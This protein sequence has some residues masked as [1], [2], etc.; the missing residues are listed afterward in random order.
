MKKET[1]AKFY[2]NYRLYIF[3]IMVALSSLFL[4]V[5]AIYPQTAKLIGNQKAQGDLINKS[6]F[7]ETK[8]LA[9]ESYDQ[10]DLSRK[11]GFALSAYPTDKDFGN[12]VGLLQQLV[13]QSG[14]NITSLALGNVPSKADVSSSYEIKLQITGAKN[15]LAVLLSNLEN[16]ARLMRVNSIDVSSGPN[17]QI[18]DVSLGVAV[19]YSSA[20]QSFGSVDSPVTKL[21]QADE[22]LITRLAKVS[23]VSVSPQAP[24]P[25]LP[26][27]KANPFE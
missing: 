11:V 2:L 25:S 22:E 3:P 17:S 23:P 14:F 1:I 21:S 4:I 16:S 6:Q 13:G 18:V 8:V 9:L 19:L 10:E 5:F 26:R 15:L 24:A 20:P 12:V 7:L 27:G